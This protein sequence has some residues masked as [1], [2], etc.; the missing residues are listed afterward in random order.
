MKIE[1]LGH[2]SFKITHKGG[3]VITDP[4]SPSYVGLPFKK[5]EANLLLSSHAHED[6]NYLENITGEPF[7]ISAPGEYEVGGVKVRG[8][9][10][11]HDDK[12]GK[13]RGRNTIYTFE[14]EGVTFCHL[15]DLGHSLSEATAEELPDLGVLFVPVGGIFTIDASTASKVVAQLEPS[16]IIPMHYRVEGMSKGFSE[17][18]PVK[19][20][21]EEM[22]V[23]DQEEV[24]KLEVSSTAL[25]EEPQVVVL[26]PT[27]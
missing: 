9:S 24:A 25:P 26:Q 19:T 17:L 22:G 1:Y 13:E 20:F 8:F 5:T 14:V 7:V 12:E 11:F 4:F 16:Y 23:E 15:G 18:A 27:G 6:H 3:V 21:L 10:S 2:S